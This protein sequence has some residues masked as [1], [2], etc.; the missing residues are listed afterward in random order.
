MHAE[1]HQAPVASDWRN[2]RDDMSNGHLDGHHFQN[3]PFPP[4]FPKVF[5][6]WSGYFSLQPNGKAAR[7]AT[8]RH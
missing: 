4:R 8:R 5:E 3:V 1:D 7:R 2:R 6:P